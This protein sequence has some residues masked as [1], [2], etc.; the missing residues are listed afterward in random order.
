MSGHLR[1]QTY[2]QMLKHPAGISRKRTEEQL[3]E[4]IISLCP[5]P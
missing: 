5:P 4:L 2:R 1:E 3:C